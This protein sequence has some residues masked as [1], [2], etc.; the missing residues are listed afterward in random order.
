MRPGCTYDATDAGQI[1]D[2]RLT[3]FTA[4]GVFALLYVQGD[5]TEEAGSAGSLRWLP[6]RTARALREKIAAIWDDETTA[7]CEKA[8]IRLL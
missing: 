4:K 6:Q 2:T 5:V 1:A 8:G 3:T 7:A